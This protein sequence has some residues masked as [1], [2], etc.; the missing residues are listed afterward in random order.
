ME[1]NDIYKDQQDIT[2]CMD[3]DLFEANIG[4]SKNFHGS[5]CTMMFHYKQDCA[6]VDVKHKEEDGSN[7][8]NWREP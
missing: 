7:S 5:Y 3:C 4:V 6:F 1:K 2:M 8:R